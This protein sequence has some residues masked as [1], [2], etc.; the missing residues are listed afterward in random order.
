MASHVVCVGRAVDLPDT[1]FCEGSGI[2]R[3]H[4]WRLRSEGIRSCAL[5]KLRFHCP[6]AGEE[7]AH[8]VLSASGD[9]AD[10]LPLPSALVRAAL[11]ALP[12]APRRQ[13]DRDSQERR[14][15]R[16]LALP[17]STSGLL[18]A[19]ICTES[20]PLTMDAEG[21]ARA[22]GGGGTIV[23]RAP[24]APRCFVQLVS[25]RPFPHCYAEQYVE[26]PTQVS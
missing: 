13:R 19:T 10:R 20:T 14:L 3:T 23:A 12:P 24:A 4:A 6:D 22:L 18:C 2:L 8:R 25:R 15:Q 21:A 7:S 11:Q 16:L 17:P 9:A 1:L 5:Q 26:E